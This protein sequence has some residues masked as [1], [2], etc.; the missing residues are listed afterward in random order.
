MLD[1]RLT[2]GLDIRQDKTLDTWLDRALE[3][4]PDIGMNWVLDKSE[5]GAEL[6]TEQSLETGL[7]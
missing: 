6:R 2:K 3:K 5:H 7:D 1:G 4:I